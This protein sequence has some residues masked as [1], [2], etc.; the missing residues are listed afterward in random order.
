M[1]LA[2]NSLLFSISHVA[3]SVKEREERHEACSLGHAGGH[4]AH[5]APLLCGPIQSN[6]PITSCVCM[7]RCVHAQILSHKGITWSLTFQFQI[8]KFSPPPISNEAS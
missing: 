4:R 6:I 1:S 5:A 8:E 2:F 7:Q 3:K